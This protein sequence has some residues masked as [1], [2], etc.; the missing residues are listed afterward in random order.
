MTSDDLHLFVTVAPQRRV[1]INLC[2]WGKMLRSCPDLFFLT[3]RMVAH[4]IRY[5]A[6]NLIAGGVLP[7]KVKQFSD[8]VF[9]SSPQHFTLCKLIER[10]RTAEL[11]R[12]RDFIQRS[13]HL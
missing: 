10:R 6:P 9:D 5:N 1:A 8:Y 3:Y 7:W 2:P 13:P 11:T 12:R 4:D